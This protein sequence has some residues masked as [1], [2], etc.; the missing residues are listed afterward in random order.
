MNGPLLVVGA[1]RSGTTLVGERLLG[2]HPDVLYWSEPS[3]VW[4][5]GNAY[6]LHDMLSARDASQHVQGRI[7]AAFEGYAARR[8]EA[9]LVEKTPANSLRMSFVLSVFPEARILHVVRDGRQAVRSAVEEWQGGGGAALDSA[10]VR[11]RTLVPR[12]VHLV[13]R[14]LRLRERWVGPRTPL[15]LPAYL[16]RAVGFFGRQVLHTSWLPWGPRFPGIMRARWQLGLIEVAA[17]QWQLCVQGARSV[18]QRLGDAY[19]E[20]SYEDLQTR[21][22]AT[23]EVLRE[24]AGLAPNENWTRTCMDLLHPRV[25]DPTEKLSETELERIEAIVAATLS[26]FGYEPVHSGLERGARRA[27]SA[28]GAGGVSNDGADD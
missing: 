25:V 5:Y 7:R 4:R 17:L 21:P 23:L 12:L 22:E 6:K 16:L 2:A 18:R 20:V 24:F 28:S 13:G 11:Q 26:E 14:D 27:A 10:D 19:R 1:A 9:L 3:F 8:P 15:E